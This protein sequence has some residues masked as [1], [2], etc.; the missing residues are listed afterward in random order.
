M[1]KK[2]PVEPV[3]GCG[4]VPLALRSWGILIGVVGIF[5]NS[6]GFDFSIGVSFIFIAIGVALLIA[7]SNRANQ[8]KKKLAEEHAEY[9][10]NLNKYMSNALACP[11]CSRKDAI[12]LTIISTNNVKSSFTRSNDKSGDIWRTE[13]NAKEGCKY[14]DYNSPLLNFN[15]EN[16]SWWVSDK[17]GSGASEVGTSGFHSEAQI[18]AKWLAKK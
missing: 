8:E 14:C 18:R 5:G 4:M 6:M 10:Q 2:Q 15:L 13:V 9:K 11:K 12:T 7:G 17:D 3:G 1:V 16:R